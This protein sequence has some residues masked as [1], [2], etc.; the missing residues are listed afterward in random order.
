MTS[1]KVLRSGYALHIAAAALISTCCL[2]PVSVGQTADADAAARGEWRAAITQNT[3]LGEG[4]FQTSY[5]S[6][7][8]EQV[9]CK[10]LHP[11]IRPVIRK[12][13]AGQE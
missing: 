4:C 3:E 10:V 12:P 13:G 8:W 5:P 11:R 2:Q 1:R 6:I 7:D 9:E